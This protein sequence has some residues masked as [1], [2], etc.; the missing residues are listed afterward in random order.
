MH[1]RHYQQ[2]EIQWCRYSEYALKNLRPQKPYRFGQLLRSGFSR[3]TSYSNGHPYA[4]VLWNGLKTPTQYH[5]DFIMVF[6]V[7]PADAIDIPSLPIFPHL[8][9]SFAWRAA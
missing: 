2:R 1:T 7:T 4:V 8:L 3:V 6:K 5:S 9:R